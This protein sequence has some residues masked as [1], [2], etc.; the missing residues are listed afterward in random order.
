M[1]PGEWDIEQAG[2][3]ATDAVCHL[4]Q[5]YRT[6]SEQEREVLDLDR[7]IGPWEARIDDA[8]QAGDLEGFQEALRGYMRAGGRAIE[9]ARTKAGAA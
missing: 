5:H 8:A 1:R 2:E 3:L 9:S 4:G 6:L 7:F